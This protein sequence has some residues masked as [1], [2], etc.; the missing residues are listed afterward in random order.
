MEITQGGYKQ[1]IKVKKQAE[2]KWQ[3]AKCK[4]YLPS[5]S[6]ASSSFCEML[7]VAWGINTM[8]EHK[9]AGKRTTQRRRHEHNGLFLYEI[10]VQQ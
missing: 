3:M 10:Q 2:T 7:E 5:L 9:Q 8:V 6:V 4:C 1:C